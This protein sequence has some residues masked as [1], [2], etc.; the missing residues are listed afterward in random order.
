MPIYKVKGLKKY[1]VRVNYVDQDG[2]YKAKYGTA[3]SYAEAAKKYQELYEGRYTI[4][5][6]TLRELCESFLSYVEERKRESSI[7]DYKSCIKI[8]LRTID[9]NIYIEDISPAFVRKWQTQ[10]LQT[11]HAISYIRRVNRML[12]T[13]MNYG[14]I[15]YGLKKNSVKLA[16]R[17]P[18]ADTAEKKFYTLD[19]FNRFLNGIDKEKDISYWV[20]FNVLFYSGCR[21]GEIMALYPS[22]I[23]FQKQS[24]SI[25][26]TFFHKHG[27]DYITPPKTDKSIRNV[28]MPPFLMQILQ[29]YIQRLPDSNMRIFFNLTSEGVRYKAAKACEK[30]G[31]KRI[32]IHDFRHS[33]ISFLISKEVPIL[34]ISHRAGHASAEITYK[35]Y[36][37]LYPERDR[38]IANREEDDFKTWGV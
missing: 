33:A 28:S 21:I 26:K 12:S 15:Y 10:M 31:V 37:H 34:E 29:D 22:D 3:N 4:K 32:R 30:T 7:N 36:A 20:L 23:D 9:E 1:R 19:E 8:I 17:L 2:T 25:T 5:K 16:G 35:V 14:E 6:T 27:K 13:L 38:E 11:N 24:I 18:A